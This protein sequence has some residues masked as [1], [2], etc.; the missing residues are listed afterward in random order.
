MGGGL[1]P[2]GSKDCS[3]LVK[4]FYQCRRQRGMLGMLSGDCTGLFRD[5][6]ACLDEE[7]GGIS[8][9]EL[10]APVLNPS[11][12]SPDN[13]ERP[14]YRPQGSAWRSLGRQ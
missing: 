14:T 11:L 13:D 4:E 3:E 9:E 2:L 10:S 1:G 12:R 7:V 8:V 5:M 6:H